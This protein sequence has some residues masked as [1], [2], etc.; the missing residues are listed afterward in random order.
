MRPQS[1][2]AKGRRLQQHVVEQLLRTFPELAPD[3]VRST[4]MGCAGEDVV[5]SP[6]ARQLLP[7]AFECK[8]Q[9]RLNLWSS[10]E[11][12]ESN[13]GRFEPVLV[14][15]RN[16]EQPRVVLGLSHFL[17]LIRR[18]DAPAETLRASIGRMR[19][20]LDRVEQSMRPGA[21]TRII[22]ESADKEAAEEAAEE[23]ESDAESCD[24]E[25]SRQDGGGGNTERLD[26]EGGTRSER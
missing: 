16:R 24:A 15:K 12:C 23:D 7:Y 10:I 20:E 14:F 2:K 22:S 6:R 25:E 19:Q 11:Q 26:E 9:E 17:A 5:L 8:N 21:P 3:D 1:A 18:G 4:S 13:A